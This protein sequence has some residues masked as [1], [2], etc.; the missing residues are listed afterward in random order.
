MLL[1]IDTD[2]VFTFIHFT[3]LD[4]SDRSDLLYR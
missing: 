1:W 4:F 2:F 3:V